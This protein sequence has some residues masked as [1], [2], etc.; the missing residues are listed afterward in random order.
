MFMDSSSKSLMRG[1]SGIC[2]LAMMMLFTM[3]S[4][5]KTFK[6]KGDTGKDIQ[7]VI[8][9]AFAKGGGKVV[10]P[11]GLYKVGSIQLRSNVELHLEKDA[12]LMGGDKSEDYDSF[13]EEICAIKPE[14]SS[15]VLVY[16]Y[17]SRNIAITGEGVIDGQGPKFFDTSAPTGNY[18]KPPVERPRMVQFVG[19]DG[20]RLEGVTFKDSPCWTMLIRLCENV[21]VKGITITADQR[22]INNDGI[23]FDSCKHVRVSGSRFKTCDDCLILRAMRETPDQHV[24]CEDIIVTDCNL[25]SR[26]QTVRLGCPSDDTIRNALFKNIVATG[27]NGIFADYPTRYLR[28]DDEGYMDISNIVFENYIGSF[29]GSAVQIVSEPGV[30]IRRADGFV[31]RNVE[32]RSAHT[33]R[34]IGNAGHEVGSVLLENFKAEVSAPDEPIEVRGCDGLVFKDVILNGQKCPDGPVAGNPGSDSPLTRG[35]VVSWEQVKQK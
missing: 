2:L 18:P 21:E 15:K 9:K 28:P 11:A 17:N 26:C 8:D 10:V 16:A 25:D 5:V 30:K 12:L 4:P 13:P 23:D 1:G 27:N 34:F 3:C 31:F 7:A 29:D 14:N 6:V 32:V 19:C 20:I 24:V 22:M 35:K 33:L